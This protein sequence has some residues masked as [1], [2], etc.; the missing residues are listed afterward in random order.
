[1]QQSY[2]KNYLSIYFFQAL[3]IIL[4]LVSMFIVV[5][6]LSSNQTVYGVYSICTSV[7]ILLSYA[8]LGFLNAGTKYASE[9]YARGDKDNEL[10][11]I[12]FTHFVLLTIV[13]L[14][15]FVFIFLSFR[16][17]LLIKD[18]APGESRQI[19]QKLLLILGIFSPIVVFQRMV[20]MV[21]IVRVESYKVQRVAILGNLVKIL[22]VFYFFRPGYYDIIGYYLTFNI[23]NVIV[24][25][26]NYIQAKHSAGYTPSMLLSKLKF[27]KEVFMKI[28]DLAFSS[29][30]M[31]IAW[32]VFYELD[33]I[34]IGKTLGAERVAVYAIGLTILGFI[35]SLLGVFFSP[36][37]ARF[38]HFVGLGEWDNLKHFFMKIMQIMFPV[39]VYP[40]VAISI[41]AGPITVSW[42]GVEYSESICIVMI[43]SL[44]NI[45]AFVSYPCGSLLVAQEKI[46]D[47]Y[48]V[49]GLQ[50]VVY[51]VGV[52]CLIS[53]LNVM[54]FAFMKCL[55]FVLIGLFYI[56]YS[57]RFLK[58]SIFDYIKQVILPY[59]PGLLI[60]VVFLLFARQWFY[61]DKSIT[62]L[63][64]NAALM[65]G[66]LIIAFVATF[67]VSPTIK[68]QVH[69]IVNKYKN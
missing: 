21:F 50:P 54:G 1:M 15:S 28:K 37:D 30:F 45:F 18:L 25:I 11:I 9:Y 19:A 61:V 33:S 43:L 42:V 35:R 59:V 12:G 24:V 53:S 40:L 6:H 26:I 65:G 17:E 13:L 68:E 55:V 64:L 29:L 56:W 5:P 10:K 7:T 67:F 49:N 58:I 23:V 27:S 32:I 34:V 47:L 20:Q 14:L 44:C 57:S 16:P 60:V 2:T 31:T 38:N 36:F 4:G 46:K 8:D 39:V 3:S 66:V 69:E 22:S 52:F 41:M 51:W 48:V 62:N 63:F